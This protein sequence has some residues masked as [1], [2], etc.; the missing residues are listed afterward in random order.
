MGIWGPGA[1]FCVFCHFT[2][3][4]QIKNVLDIDF[5]SDT[6][7]YILFYIGIA[8]LLGVIFHELG[9]LLVDRLKLFFDFDKYGSLA[10]LKLK[11]GK[12]SHWF[13]PMSLQYQYRKILTDCD[14]LP[15]VPFD[16]AYSVLKYTKNKN[17]KRIDTY[18]SVYGL[19]RGLWI[20]FIVHLLL[21]IILFWSQISLWQIAL[22]LFLIYVFFCRT[23][24]YYISWVMNVFIQ[25]SLLNEEEDD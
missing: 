3:Y 10:K 13:T 19:S 21:C 8:Y 4:S 6:W 23:V 11:S 16:K 9:K 17:L 5:P 7:A 24:R 15:S 20:G 25:Y 18:H 12:N 1:I 22:D 14:A 2:L